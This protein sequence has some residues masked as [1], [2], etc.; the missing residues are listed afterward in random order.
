VA[1]TGDVNR[2]GLADVVVG[3]PLASPKARSQAGAAYVV[4]GGGHAAGQVDLAA[5]GP[6]GGF[7]VAGAQPGDEA[8]HAVALMRGNR[9]HA[10]ATVRGM[11]A[12]KAKR[13]PK[14]GGCL[15]R[16]T[17][18]NKTGWVAVIVS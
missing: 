16:I 4:Y 13:R 15:L 12:L 17:R 10:R 7:A 9:V 3:A 6:A 1:G 2:A 5:L 18:A 8:G 14:G 11:T